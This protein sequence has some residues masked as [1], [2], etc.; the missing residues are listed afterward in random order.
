V[1]LGDVAL[2]VGGQ[3]AQAPA[4]IQ[5]PPVLALAAP[6][7]STTCPR[8]PPADRPLAFGARLL[9]P[10]L[11]TPVFRRLLGFGC[12][13]SADRSAAVAQVRGHHVLSAFGKLLPRATRAFGQKQPAC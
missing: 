6:P 1:D 8:D 13:P 10:L 3:Q 9:S 5:D 7:T 2:D 11:I 4:D 12:Q